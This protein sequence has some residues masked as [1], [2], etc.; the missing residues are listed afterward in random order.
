MISGVTADAFPHSGCRY[1]RQW[2][3]TCHANFSAHSKSDLLKTTILSS[4]ANGNTESNGALN[5]LGESV[6]QSQDPDKGEL[7]DVSIWV[8][9]PAF[10]SS[11]V[12]SVKSCMSG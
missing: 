7:P 4:F 12:R 5:F 11:C 6:I 8:R 3:G 10:L 9:N 2:D 1:R